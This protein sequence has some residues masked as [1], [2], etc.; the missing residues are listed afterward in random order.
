MV[1]TSETDTACS[2]GMASP[3][4]SDRSTR[5]SVSRAPAGP[6]HTPPTQSSVCEP[7]DGPCRT[8]PG[9][10]AERDMAGGD[11]RVVQAAGQDALGPD[12]GGAGRAMRELND[13]ESG[14][15]GRADGKG[16]AGFGE[17]RYRPVQRVLPE[18]VGLVQ[19]V[20]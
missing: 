19:E 13:L 1:S 8:L 12:R 18:S 10:S 14:V 15:A 20:H 2:F 16:H 3:S 5:R 4:S 9:G 6:P 17:W 7:E 11:H